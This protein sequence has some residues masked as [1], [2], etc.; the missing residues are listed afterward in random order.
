MNWGWG[1]AYDGYFG[2]DDLTTAGGTS[3][4]Y[5]PK[6][7]DYILKGIVPL[8]SNSLDAGVPTIISPVNYYCSTNTLSVSVNLQ[9]FGSSTLTS[10]NVSYVLDGGS[11]QSQAWSGTLVTYQKTTV[12]LPNITVTPGTHTLVIC[13]NSPNTSTD[14]NPANDC[15]TIIFNVTAGGILPIVEGFENSTCPSGVLPN[16]NWN[17]SSSAGGIDFTITS[18][19][20]ASGSQSCMLNNFNNTA[21]DTSILQ[22]ANFFNLSTLT[23]PVV[24]FAAAY[25]QKATSNADK[26]QIL[27]STDCGNSWISRKVISASTLAS[28]AGGT[29]TT[30]YV[31]TPS[32]FST[33]TVTLNSSETS[34][35]NVMFRWAFIA[36]PTSP[37]NNLYIDNINIAAATLGIQNIETLVGLNL[38]P[39]PSVG[40]VNIDFNL[41]E[42][43][44]VSVNVTDMLGRT[45]ETIASKSY[46]SGETTLTIGSGNTY[47]A[48]IYLVNINIDGQRV[49]KKIVIQ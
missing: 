2:V 10:C 19:S 40:Q 47:Q 18:T 25:Q 23:T 42:Q 24:T 14:Q 35:P 44:N 34:S 29:S 43:H 26:L 49:S 46:Q 15:S 9:N 4:V 48:G 11:T 22:T 12:N 36:D 21:G 32:Q 28:L 39:N 30:A 13:S 6:Y 7:N 38:Y 17:V 8:T 33:Y 3:A 1:G 20:E 37:G 41:S 5:D 27:V 45:V 31:P 16:S